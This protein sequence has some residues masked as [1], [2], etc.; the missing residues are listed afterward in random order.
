MGAEVRGSPAIAGHVVYA[1]ATDGELAAFDL[2]GNRGCTGT[3]RV[4]APIWTKTLAGTL[5]APS[6][7]RSK[8][9][10]GGSELH[11]YRVLVNPAPAAIES[12]TL[13]SDDPDVFGI[14]FPQADA[15]HTFANT[16]NV[17]GNSRLTFTR[18][19]D[20]VGTDLTSCAT[21]TSDSNW[22]DQEGAALRVHDVVGGVKA[23]TVTK[24]V[25]FAANWIF[26]V[27]VWDTS[28]SPVA[29]QIAGFDLGSVFWPDHQAVVP[30]PWTLCAQV[31]GSTVSFI[32]WPSS[33]PRPAWDDPTHGGS[34][35]LPAGYEDAGAAGWYVGHLDPGDHADFTDMSASVFVPLHASRSATTPSTT[36][37][38]APQ[39]VPSLP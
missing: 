35:T 9:F 36:P 21:W 32:V 30:L 16:S 12:A 37:P 7:A 22:H 3:P 15:T 18:A 39:L 14:S 20:A 33:E 5:S 24:N 11:A 8:L 34:V 10:I 17:A 2:A 6:I 38:R 4:C 13:T 25:V 29:V 1:S 28:R 19:G 31:V 26:N 27:H 23:I